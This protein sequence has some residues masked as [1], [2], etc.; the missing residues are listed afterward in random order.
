MQI[1]IIE[2]NKPGTH[3]PGMPRGQRTNP[4]SV[5]TN[6]GCITRYEPPLPDTVAA[7]AMN[8]M[9][10]E[11]FTIERQQQMIDYARRLHA[12]HPEWSEQ[13]VGRKVAEYFNLKLIK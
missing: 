10:A 4:P 6:R 11:G 2:Q 9:V 1:Q 3:F 5:E 8:K 7:K 13:R 12:K